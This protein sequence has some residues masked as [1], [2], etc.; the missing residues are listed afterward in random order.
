MKVLVINGSLKGERSNR[1][2]LTKAFLAGASWHN[3]EVI[4][5]SKLNIKG[6]TGCYGCWTATPGQCVI[7]DD[8]NEL[9]PKLAA[10]LDVVITSFPLYGSNFPGQL[11]V[12]MDRQL[13]LSLPAMLPN[14]NE[15]GEHP[16]RG[17]MAGRKYVFIS[18]C[19]FWTAEGNY[20]AIE[21][22]L[23]RG[24]ATGNYE[25]LFTGQGELFG[26]AEKVA[27]LQEYT[28]NYLKLVH[29]AGEEYA[30]GG[31]ISQ[32][33]KE[34]LAVPLFPREQFEEMA[35]GSW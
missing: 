22:L 11:K 20:G 9:L 2:I 1:L 23:S 6:C 15:S 27:Q 5:L 34:E 7:K 17:D 14:A 25:T 8:M 13:P 33:L 3:A 10:W 4:H 26:E 24:F 12:F 31:V 32:K 28:H 19:G 29:K 21:W 18:T 30:E 16:L 35:N